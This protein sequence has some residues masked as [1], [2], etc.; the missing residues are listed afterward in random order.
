MPLKNISNI[1][2]QIEHMYSLGIL[3]L[4]PSLKHILLRE[5]ALLPRLK[6]STKKKM[7]SGQT[8]TLLETRFL[9][10]SQTQF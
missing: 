4:Q 2:F 7:E 9:A 1:H 6:H 3:D 10:K 8:L 5:L